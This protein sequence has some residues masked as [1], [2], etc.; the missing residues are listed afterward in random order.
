LENP[1]A[2]PSGRP[3]VWHFPHWGNQGGSPG[4]AIRAGKWKL[5][6]WGWPARTELFDLEADPG[7]RTDLA[8][9]QPETV[10]ALSGQIDAFLAETRAFLPTKNPDFKGEF[11]KW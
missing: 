2:A 5:I 7:E 1:A 10:A 8:S 6:R 11:L 9:R 4:T 3:L